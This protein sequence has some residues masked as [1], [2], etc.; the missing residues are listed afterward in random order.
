MISRFG[1]R[2]QARCGIRR[3]YSPGDQRTR[4]STRLA[5]ARAD[6]ARKCSCRLGSQVLVPTRLASAR[7]DSARK[8]SCRLG[9]QAL[10]PQLALLIMSVETALNLPVAGAAR[11]ENR[12]EH[13][14]DAHSRRAAKR[15][16]ELPRPGVLAQYRLYFQITSW[17]TGSKKY[18]RVVSIVRLSGSPAR[19]AV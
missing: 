14:D 4:E 9:S 10:V 7:A 11:S 5:S 8:C 19:A 17:L 1:S 18:S 12:G 6:S 16:A 2:C 13:D 3:R 15:I